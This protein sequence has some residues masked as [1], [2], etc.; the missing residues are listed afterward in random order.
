MESPKGRRGQRW[1]SILERPQALNGNT[2]DR[3]EDQTPWDK[4]KKRL[5]EAKDTAVLWM[6]QVVGSK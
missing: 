4:T 2:E 1:D 6:V 3:G 5:E